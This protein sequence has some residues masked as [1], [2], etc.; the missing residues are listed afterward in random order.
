M[1]TIT[2]N[3]GL[4]RGLNPNEARRLHWRKA[5]RIRKEWRAVGNASGTQAL[6][7]GFDCVDP[8]VIE[9]EFIH[10]MSRRRD[11]DNYVISMKPFIDG[12]VDSGVLVDD[13]YEHLRHGEHRFTK[14]TG[15]QI[16]IRI[17]QAS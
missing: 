8:A 16:V 10:K 5:A 12:L 6:M 15:D 17:R 7:K 3:H 2:L 1:I 9:F 4:P 11:I 13:S 14:G